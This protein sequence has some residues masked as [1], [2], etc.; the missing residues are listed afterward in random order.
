MPRSKNCK[1]INDSDKNRVKNLHFNQGRKPKEI[2]QILGIKIKSIF[3]IIER[4]RKEAEDICMPRK[5]RGGNKMSIIND[6]HLNFIDHCLSLNC[7]LTQK[8]LTNLLNNHFGLSLSR[9]TLKR[10]MIRKGYTLKLVKNVPFTK[11]NN[12]TINERYDYCM[13]LS[14]VPPRLIYTN[15]IFIDESG[16]NSS[17]KRKQG[18]NIKG[19]PAIDIPVAPKSSNVSIIGAMTGSNGIIHFEADIGKL[20]GARIIIFI[21]NLIEK[22]LTDPNACGVDVNSPVYIVWDNAAIHKAREVRENCF[23]D[24]IENLHGLN[25]EHKFLPPYSPFLNPIEEAWS[26][27]KF[28]IRSGNI[29]AN[30]TLMDRIATAMRNISPNLAQSFTD[31]MTKFVQPSLAKK[32]IISDSGTCNQKEMD[33][34]LRLQEETG[35]RIVQQRVELARKRAVLAREKRERNKQLCRDRRQ[36]AREEKLRERMRRGDEIR[37][38]LNTIINNVAHHSFH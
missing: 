34:Y 9:S 7:S 19:Y 2:A 25:L 8:Q 27:S 30:D 35:R 13:W 28:E 14:S 12:E 15:L 23:S 29:N 1:D 22:I 20:N 10:A 11:N 16:F 31:H 17:L 6:D 36:R 26:H 33:R 4:L 3:S 21:Q 37:N 18:Y 32:P 5:P 24:K 38:N